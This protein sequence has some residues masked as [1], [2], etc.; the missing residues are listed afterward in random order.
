MNLVNVLNNFNRFLIIKFNYNVIL[1]PCSVTTQTKCD[2]ST[3]IIIQP[4]FY[5]KY[6]LN[7]LYK[8]VQ[9]IVM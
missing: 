6:K 2:N 9:Y 4:Q 8:T 5:F 1:I 3:L 7:T